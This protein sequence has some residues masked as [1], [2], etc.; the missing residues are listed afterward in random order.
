MNKLAFTF[1]VLT[2]AAHAAMAADPAKIDWSAVPATKLQL[3]Y[4]GQSSYEWLRGE[5]HEGAWRQVKRGDACVACHDEKDAEKDIGDK[6]VKGGRLEPTPVA[7]KPGHVDLQVQ[8]AY[9]DKNAYLRFQWKTANPYP[10]TEHQYLRYDGHEWKVYGYPKLDQVVRE[11][12]QPGIYEDRM[13]VMIDD[14]KV[15]GFA[16]Q[17]CWLTCHDGERDMPH[18]FTKDE[19]AAN[20]LLTAIKKSDVRKYVPETRSDPSDWKTGKPVDEIAKI[21]AAG[22][23]LDLIQW[24]AHRSHPV[25][26]VDDGY[27]LEWRLADAGKDPFGSNA[28]A[29]TH[30]PKYMWDE[31]K[32][33][34][35][36]ITAEQL[37]KG[38]HFLIRE[39]NAVPFDPKAAWKEGDMIP[40]YVVSR[41]DAKG[42]A[43]DNNAIASWQ[44]GQWTVVMIRPLGLAN[45]DD[46]GL[47]A[48]GVYNV[49]FAVHDDNITT[50]GHF[51]S[52]VKT[53]G[54]GAPGTK[55]D[56]TAVKLP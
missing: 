18:Q 26:M 52:F 53:L 11:G 19:V 54:L 21:K 31:K 2:L 32:V 30:Q 44:D 5:G 45:A 14:G 6:L 28:D 41:E 35:R 16:Q 50:R 34:Y 10:G 4:P 38:D 29:A 48:G 27:V 24:R 3:F 51:V 7:G 8:A 43:A 12:K 37:R 9:D 36:S 20:A 13:S 33:G 1:G 23:F 46:K 40:D 39:Q 42:S 25:G 22:G 55:A 49:G 56:I 15:P 17:G 47:K